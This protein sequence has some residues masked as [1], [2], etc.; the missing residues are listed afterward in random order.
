MLVGECMIRYGTRTVHT[1]D[2]F[3]IWPKLQCRHILFRIY[4]ILE[5]SCNSAFTFISTKRYFFL[6]NVVCVVQSTFF[7]IGDSMGT[8]M[9]YFS[10]IVSYANMRL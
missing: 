3:A 2:M 4:C 9:V 5:F 8:V 7:L 10:F 1:N 6:A